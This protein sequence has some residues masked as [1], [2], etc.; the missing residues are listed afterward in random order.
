MRHVFIIISVMLVIILGV[1]FVSTFTV[2]ER[3]YVVLTQFGKPTRTI[4]TSGLNFKLP[5]FLETVRPGAD[6]LCKCVT[7]RRPAL[8]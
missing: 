8:P 1:V 3:E 6:R 5:G 2:S 4:R 7:G